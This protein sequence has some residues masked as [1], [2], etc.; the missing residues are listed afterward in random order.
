MNEE[1]HRALNVSLMCSCIPMQMLP[2]HKKQTDLIFLILKC[3]FAFFQ[4]IPYKGL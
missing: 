2:S 3:A 4:S 1:I